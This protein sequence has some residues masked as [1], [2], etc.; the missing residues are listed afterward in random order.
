MSEVS[1]SQPVDWSPE[2]G[3][4]QN[5]DN[6]RDFYPRKSSGINYYYFQCN[7]NIFL[8]LIDLNIGSGLS[9]GLIMYIDAHKDDYY[10]TK[11][12]TEGFKVYKYK[13]NTNY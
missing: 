2:N 5:V 9:M 4:P 7:S 10:C 3:Y 6:I 11:T 12:Y 1:G 8:L 13:K